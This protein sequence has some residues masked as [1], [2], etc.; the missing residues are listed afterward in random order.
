MSLV[1]AWR[2]R[3]S[4]ASRSELEQCALRVLIGGLVVLWVFFSRHVPSWTETDTILVCSLA[5]WL[6]VALGFLVATWTWS[7]PSIS[8]RVLGIT[9]DVGTITAALYF[10]DAHGSVI[11]FTYLFIIFGNGFRYG[12]SYLFLSQCV[13]LVG[14]LLVAT[15]VSW[16]KSHPDVSVGWFVGLIVLP[17][18]VGVLFERLKA[19]RAKAE[20]A[21]KECIE[22][23]PRLS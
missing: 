9:F 5:A 19:A 14:L 22:R 13:S 4:G 23:Q 1:S 12:R 3:S 8:R 10:L 7:A 20:E 2:E 6:L 16:W 11:I 18:Y 17:F 15:N 21:L